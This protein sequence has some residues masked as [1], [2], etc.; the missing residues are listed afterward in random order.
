MI[1][2]RELL[3]EI[4]NVRAT[5]TAEFVR[6]GT[7]SGYV[8]NIETLLFK[9]V[10][11]LEGKLLTDHIWFTTN[12]SFD[13]L[14]LNV[15]ECIKFDARVKNYEKGYKGYREDVYIPIAQDFKLSHPT[16]II[17]INGGI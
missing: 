7:K 6:Y 3:K 4:K 9:N 1:K 16:K 13:K 8:S 17:K 15:G 11:D 2:M 10:K 14:K 12:K 5:F